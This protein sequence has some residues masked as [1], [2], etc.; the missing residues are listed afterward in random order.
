MPHLPTAAV[1]LGRA[2][3]GTP[4]FNGTS[5]EPVLVVGVPRSG[6]SRGVAAPAIAG[7]PG[8]VVVT[9]VLGAS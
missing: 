7:W 5:L 6:K 8:P 9:V 3:D 1:P 2:P 4:L